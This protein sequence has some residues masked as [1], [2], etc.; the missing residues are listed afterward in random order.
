MVAKCS[1]A[2]SSKRPVTRFASRSAVSFASDP[3]F[4]IGMSPAA[5]GSG[6]Q[7]ARELDSC[8]VG[9]AVS[10]LHQLRRVG[11][12]RVCD[13]R[14]AVSGG[15]AELARLEVRKRRPPTS[16][17]SHPAPPANTSG[18]RL[19]GL[20]HVRLVELGATRPRPPA[21][22]RS[23]A[24]RSVRGLTPS[25][26]CSRSSFCAAGQSTLPGSAEGRVEQSRLLARV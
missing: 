17:T 23:G 1:T 7:T 24:I 20:R 15:H 11:R 2:T 26:T 12:H 21:P 14:V 3:C 22:V 4:R 10:D 9:E 19:G 6:R 25:P 13:V 5:R 8:R 18:G 16:H